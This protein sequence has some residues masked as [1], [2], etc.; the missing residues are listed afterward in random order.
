MKRTLVYEC[1]KTLTEK[2]ISRWSIQNNHKNTYAMFGDNDENKALMQ[3]L[4]MSIKY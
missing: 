4:L 2:A 1:F 3:T